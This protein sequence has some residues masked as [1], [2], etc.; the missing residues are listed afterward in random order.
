MVRKPQLYAKAVELRKIGRSYLEIQ[1]TIGVSKSTLSDWLSDKTWSIKLKEKL[2]KAQKEG[3]RTSLVYANYAR[4]KSKEERFKKYKSEAKSDYQKLSRNPLFLLGLG[5]YWGEGEKVSTSGRVSVIN[6][7]PGMLKVIRNFYKHCLGIPD[8]Q[9][10]IA[11]Y[12]YEDL[13]PEEVKQFWSKE[14]NIPRGQFIKTQ[15]LK[16]R[17]RLTKRKSKYGICSLYFSSTEVNVKIRE[18]IRLV[19]LENRAGIA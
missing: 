15:I 14:L 13:D 12:V 4:A 9:M 2:I 6:T 16:S 7:D 18:W 10:R 1:K 8:E 19:E 5:L 11:L 17:S 3:R